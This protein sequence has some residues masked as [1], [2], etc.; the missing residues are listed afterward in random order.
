MYTKE[1]FE[2]EGIRLMERGEDEQARAFLTKAAKAG[3]E[4]AKNCLRYLNMNV[5]DDDFNDTGFRASEEDL[6]DYDF[7]PLRHVSYTG[8]ILQKSLQ[9][10]RN[11]V[12]YLADDFAARC[13]VLARRITGSIAM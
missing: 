6:F 3:S 4:K 8:V 11:H 12:E 5:S 13:S 9:N 7:Q 10:V 1:Y 2:S